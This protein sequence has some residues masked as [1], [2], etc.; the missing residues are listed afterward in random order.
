MRYIAYS[1]D[2]A[3]PP[4]IFIR[5]YPDTSSD[6]VKVSTNGGTEPVWDHEGFLYYL[7]PGLVLMRIAVQT[8]P[9]LQI[10]GDPEPVYPV[11]LIGGAQTRPNY[12]Y[13]AV[14]HRFLVRQNNSLTAVPSQKDRIVIVQHWTEW[15]KR[16]LPT[17]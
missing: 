16:E 11:P 6:R 8:D 13:D 9:R 3:G 7:D 10:T 15:L 12:G 14:G 17:D 2:E 4:E 5:P 1:S